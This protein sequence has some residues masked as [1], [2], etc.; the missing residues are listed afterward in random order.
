MHKFLH[1]VKDLEELIDNNTLKEGDKLPSIRVLA[2]QYDVNK[3]TVI[4][5]LNDLEQRHI[6]YS[7]NKSGYYVIKSAMTPNHE[8]EEVID[9]ATSSPESRIFPYLDFQH[10]VNKAIDTYKQD[11]FIYGTPQGLPSLLNIMQKQL[12][13][14]QVFTKVRN[15]FVVSGIQQAL[16]ILAITPFPNEKRKILIEQPSYHLFIEHLMTYGV[17]VIGIKRTSRGIDFG[18]LEEIFK[19]ED[20]K[21]FYTIPR[22]HNPLGCSYSTEEKKKIVALAKKYDVYIVEDDYLADME[23]DT[24]VDP[25]YAYDDKSHVI[26]LKSYSKIIFPGLRIGIAVIPDMLLSV[27]TRYKRIQDIDSSML[28]Q[29][30]LEIYLKSSMFDR[31]KQKIKSCYEQKS[32]LLHAAL[33]QQFIQN[34]DL[35]TFDATVKSPLNTCIQL[36]DSLPAN[37]VITRLKKKSIWIEPI[38]NHYLP[39]FP[40]DN[41]IKLNVSHARMNDIEIGVYVLINEIRKIA[42]N[43]R[44]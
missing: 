31:H 14:Y 27:F 13:N 34:G 22:F 44:F 25:L 21:F 17:P 38:D 30:A 35:F 15:I 24:K 33:E 18:E 6:V 26:Y 29:G 28:S 11:L 10:C 9:F 19:T 7:V 3:S 32:Q 43:R 12:A 23:Q 36:N 39:S 20:I 16:S 5:A 4:R 1:I 41:L 8:E 37:E 2:N 42:T 40:K